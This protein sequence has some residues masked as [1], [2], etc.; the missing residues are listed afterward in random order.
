M[1]DNVILPMYINEIH[2]DAR[3]ILKPSNFHKH[4]G[5]RISVIREEILKFVGYPYY[6]KGA[7]EF[8]GY[9]AD[10]DWVI[11]CWIFGRMVDLPTGFP[12]YCKDLVQLLDQ[13]KLDEPKQVTEKHNA[14]ED[15]K[16]HRE[17]YYHIKKHLNKY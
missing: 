7:P 3:L 13:Y 14:L 9:F 11:F 4:V 10:Y 6:Q 5:K 2:G 8:W 1:R 12:Q 17:I 15:A 16:W